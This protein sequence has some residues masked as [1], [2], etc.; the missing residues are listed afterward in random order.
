LAGEVGTNPAELPETNPARPRTTSVSSRASTRP[1]HPDFRPQTKVESPYAR[2]LQRLRRP[3]KRLPQ[4]ESPARVRS[5]TLKWQE[6]RL[7]QTANISQRTLTAGPVR[8]AHWD[9]GTLP[10]MHSLDVFG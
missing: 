2:R 6:D 9:R 4:V 7:W 5:S 1:S 10:Q 3:P 8:S